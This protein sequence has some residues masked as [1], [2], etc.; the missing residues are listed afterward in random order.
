[1]WGWVNPTRSWDA[2]AKRKTSACRER[3]PSGLASSKLLYRLS[4]P[5]SISLCIN[6][7]V[8][9]SAFIHFDNV[10][11]MPTKSWHDNG[12]SHWVVLDSWIHARR[13]SQATIYPHY[14]VCTKDFGIVRSMG[15]GATP[16]L[17]FALL[18]YGGRTVVAGFTAN[19]FFA[20]VCVKPR[21]CQAGLLVAFKCMDTGGFQ[22]LS[23][24]SS[25]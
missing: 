8:C 13:Q 10:A 21:Q 15:Y 14:C 2:L 25:M 3:N 12:R 16:K 18:G 22:W 7:N 4:K 9:L 20:C 5:G 6:K 11:F 23:F 17:P 24:H 1:M 19:F